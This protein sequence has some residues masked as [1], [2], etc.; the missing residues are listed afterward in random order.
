MS[1]VAEGVGEG[2][3]PGVE[4]HPDLPR[5][6][7]WLEEREEEMAS[8][9]ERLVLAESPTTR[10]ELQEEV[11]RLLGE[12][13]EGAG[14]GVRRYPGTITGGQLLSRPRARDKGRPYQLIL[15]HVDT[16]WPSGTLERMPV[17]RKNG[18]MTGPGIFDMKGGL[19]QLAFALRAM[20]DLDIEPDVTPVVFLNSDEEIGS[21]ESEDRI[22]RLARRACRSL[23]LEPGLGLD[24]KLKTARRGVGRFDVRVTGRS[25]HTGL[26]PQEGASAIQELSH[27]IQKLHAMSDAR[28]GI[29]VNVGQI[30]G[31]TRPNVVAAEATAVVDVRVRT[32]EDGRWVEERMQ[33]VADSAPSTAGTKVEIVGEVGRPPMERTP[34]NQALWEGARIVGRALGLELEQGTSGGASD[35]N[36]TSQYTATLDGLGCV[37][38]G[39]HADHEY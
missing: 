27:V 26:A 13:F 21:V 19:A 15:G 1:G 4:P 28:R 33:E 3:V 39:A 24:G 23:V 34:R 2:P 7:S 9:L 32:T 18:R 6:L 31:G 35:G 5:I 10:P 22:R 8:F 37:G 11:F 12:A 30:Q 17:E 16:V 14:H 36:I 29:T 20:A 38:D 25:S